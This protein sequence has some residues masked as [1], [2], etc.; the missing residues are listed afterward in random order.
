MY[1]VYAIFVVDKLHFVDDV[2]GASH[3]VAS[4]KHAHCAAEVTPIDA[5]AAVIR[6]NRILPIML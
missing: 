1:L 4:A 6:G 5:A 3:A 2:F